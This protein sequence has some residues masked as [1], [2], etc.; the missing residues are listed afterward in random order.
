[1]AP[2]SPADIRRV[3]EVTDRLGL[4]REAVVIPLGREGEGDIRM[5]GK[6]LI[7]T[8]P[9]ADLDDWLDKLPTRIAGLELAGLQ[10][11]D[12]ESED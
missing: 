3:L 11:S 7:L 8:A 5:E 4:H 6:R 10:R 2:I 12:P 1:M 9:A